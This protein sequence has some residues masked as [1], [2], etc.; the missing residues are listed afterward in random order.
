MLLI[1][2]SFNNPFLIEEQIRLLKK[3]ITDKDFIHIIT[4]NSSD[5]K[6]REA[7]KAICD[8]ENVP[9]YRLPFSWFTKIDKR[10]S[11]SHGLALTWI[12]YN[13]VKKIQPI[14][15]GFLDH[16]IF[17]IKPYS[18][19]QKIHN[20][21]FYGRLI[22]RAPDNH[23]RKLWY[24]WAGFCFFKFDSLKNRNINFMPCKV[25]NIYFDAGGSNYFSIYS[26]YDSEKLHIAPVVN[27]YFRE[28]KIPHSDML[29]FIDND[30]CHTI[31]GSNWAKVRDKNDF[32]REFLKQ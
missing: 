1:T 6:K 8:K 10:P 20:Q 15:F 21:D 13:I 24:L 16:D 31:N 19:L 7:I 29:Q 11:Y 23:P 18:V 14:V 9:Y 27:K 30:W 26:K 5:K 3:N 12:Y 17:P 32:L 25:D 22:D 28:G 4:D 2:V